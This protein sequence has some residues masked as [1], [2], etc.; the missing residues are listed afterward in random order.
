MLAPRAAPLALNPKHPAP[1]DTEISKPAHPGQPQKGRSHIFTTPRNSAL[2]FR[3]A[4]DKGHMGAQGSLIPHPIFGKPNR[5]PAGLGTAQRGRPVENMQALR[6]SA[7][8]SAFSVMLGLLET[9]RNLILS[10][11][12]P[13]S[14]LAAIQEDGRPILVRAADPAS[15]LPRLRNQ[16]GLVELAFSV[17]ARASGSG[18]LLQ[19][20]DLG[21]QTGYILDQFCR[22]AANGSYE[23]LPHCWRALSLSRASSAYQS[24]S[25]LIP[26]RGFLRSILLNHLIS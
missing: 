19:V 4:D 11:H 3:F 21:G 18:V 23:P 5:T 6:P 20:T 7:S 24:T 2:S 13:A 22:R 16:Y 14:Y 26:N 1:G 10:G 25:G 12:E 8:L 9:L 17:S 15:E